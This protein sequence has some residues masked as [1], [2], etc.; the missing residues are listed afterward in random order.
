MRF[1]ST[2][3]SSGDRQKCRKDAKCVIIVA[4]G[5]SHPVTMVQSA[6]LHFFLGL[7]GDEGSE[8]SDN[9]SDD[10]VGSSLTK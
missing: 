4:L 6:S 9:E 3:S 8:D 1:F 5:C 7:G 10:D 2:P